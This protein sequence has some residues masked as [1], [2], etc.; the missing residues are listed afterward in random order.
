LRFLVD[1]WQKKPFSVFQWGVPNQTLPFLAYQILALRLGVFKKCFSTITQNFC[2]TTY[3]LM[4]YKVVALSKLHI[5]WKFH[6]VIPMHKRVTCVLRSF[7]FNELKEHKT[8]WPLNS[9]SKKG[10]SFEYFLNTSNSTFFCQKSEKSILVWKF[11][12]I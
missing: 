4:Y 5:V 8:I 2:I 10:V 6:N 1:F 9:K 11:L 3:V 7:L 12:W